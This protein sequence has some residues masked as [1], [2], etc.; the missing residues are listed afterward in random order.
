M[1]TTEFNNSCQEN[2]V[3]SENVVV[4]ADCHKILTI[5]NS[6]SHFITKAK[7]YV[8]WNVSVTYVANFI[9]QFF[10]YDML[11]KEKK[12]FY[13]LLMGM[14]FANWSFSVI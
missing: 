2:V 14:N 8:T 7:C 13:N 9:T 3:A 4:M 5:R 1:H 11:K 10:S 6:C 12:M